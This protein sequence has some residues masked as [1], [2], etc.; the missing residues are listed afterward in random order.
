GRTRSAH[1]R[2]APPR[3]RQRPGGQRLA[4]LQRA[5]KS[6]PRHRREP[7]R[8][9]PEAR[10]RGL[11]CLRQDLRGPPAPDHLSSD[12]GRPPRALAVPGPH[13][14][15]HSLGAGLVF[16]GYWTWTFA[17]AV[18]ILPVALSR[19]LTTIRF[20]PLRSRRVARYVRGES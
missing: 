20:A 4:L 19:T 18:P 6:A 8:P 11:R 9:C 7:E 3:N 5:E 14:G 16:F 15:A 10:E 13:G 17:F 12:G 1:P 2:E